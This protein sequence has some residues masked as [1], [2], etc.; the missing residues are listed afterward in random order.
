MTFIHVPGGRD[1]Y[2]LGG[3]PMF[4]VAKDSSDHHFWGSMMKCGLE[5]NHL[6]SLDEIGLRKQHPSTSVKRGFLL[7]RRG[8]PWLGWDF[9]YDSKEHLN[10]ILA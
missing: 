6:N 9:L 7:S 10:S 3:S 4:Q 8:T 5:S 1:V 2:S